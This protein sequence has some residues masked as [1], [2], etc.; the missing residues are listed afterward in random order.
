MKPRFKKYTIKKADTLESISK[1]LGK[2][3]HE[4]KNFHNVFSSPD[5]YIG[6][7]LPKTLK[8]LFIYP[9]FH[10]EELIRIPKVTFDA[11][12]KIEIKPFQ[13]KLLY[14]VEY[15]IK[16]GVEEH[17]IKF[18]ICISCKE[19]T[20]EN[21]FVFTIDRTTNTFINEEEVNTIADE[22]AV[23]TSSVL[24]PLEV[25]V[26]K[27][28][29]WTGIANYEDIYKRWESIKENILKEYGG[30]WVEKYL[31]LNESVLESESNVVTSLKKDWFLKSY[32]NTIYVYY[33]H[34][35][36]F[37]TNADFPI[38]PN[39][40]PVRYEIEQ[41][42]NEFIEQNNLIRIEQNGELK[43]ERSKSDLQ[44]ELNVPYY[45]VLYPNQ[46]MAKGTYRSV[47]FLNATSKWIE[48]LFLECSI[49]L[50]LEKKIQIVVSLL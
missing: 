2:S 24:Y 44:N 7:D 41:K 47:Y 12:Y 19:R 43:E 18:E 1:K 31:S 14:G 16:N 38:L 36:R 40:K 49:E 13:E 29:E 4:I 10:E 28:G 6:V 39:C 34:K 50:E 3:I 30:E 25:I 32:F 20:V 42:I 46:N 48:S 15:I 5:D 23:K 35:F 8:E 21:D 37:I 26:S 33:S 9:E 27:D 11:A 22:L 17:S 45:G